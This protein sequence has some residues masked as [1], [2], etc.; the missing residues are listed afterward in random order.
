MTEHA[1]PD[2]V[3]NHP[4]LLRAAR[5]SVA[6]GG[7]AARLRLAC[8]AVDAY[9]RWKHEAQILLE[10]VHCGILNTRCCWAGVVFLE[11]AA[12]LPASPH[13]ISTRSQRGRK[14]IRHRFLISPKLSLLIGGTTSS[15]MHL[16]FRLHYGS[17]RYNRNDKGSASNCQQIPCEKPGTFYGN[18]CP[19][20]NLG[21]IQD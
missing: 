5:R 17:R 20:F 4:A 14:S 21:T 6:S 19:L 15:P 9:S 13:R 10:A 12:K 7:A 1:D 2:L 8:S 18:R 16:R 11:R 3:Q